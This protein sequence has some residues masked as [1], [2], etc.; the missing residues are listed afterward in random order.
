MDN[1]HMSGVLF[2]DVPRPG[3]R[4]VGA[5]LNCAPGNPVPL[6]RHE[7]MDGQQAAGCDS[8]YGVFPGKR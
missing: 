6:G 1:G 3:D 8:Q 5:A 2:F 4:R 7:L